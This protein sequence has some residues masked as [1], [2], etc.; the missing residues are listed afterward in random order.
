[1]KMMMVYGLTDLIFQSAS[2]LFRILT[3]SYYIAFPRNKYMIRYISLVQCSAA[4]GSLRSSR[5]VLCYEAIA[6]DIQQQLLIPLKCVQCTVQKL[7]KVSLQCLVMVHV[8]LT[9][10]VNGSITVAVCTLQISPQY[11]R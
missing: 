11:Y 7:V 5:S 8:L 2:S 6:R 4:R 1:M 9:I 10:D 3:L